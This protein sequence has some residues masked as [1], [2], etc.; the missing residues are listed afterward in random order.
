MRA[1][2]SPN[3]A[4]TIRSVADASAPPLR[5]RPLLGAAPSGAV[6][7]PD[8]QSIYSR[9]WKPVLDYES[10]LSPTCPGPEPRF[11]SNPDHQSSL[12]SRVPER[13]D[14]QSAGA[15]DDRGCPVRPMTTADAR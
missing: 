4:T 8:W 6:R 5:G 3:G 13:I 10:S 9:S 12:D 2:S 7:R 15:D 1:G 11:A 14:W